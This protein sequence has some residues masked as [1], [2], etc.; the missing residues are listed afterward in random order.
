MTPPAV[1]R[2]PRAVVLAGGRGRRMGA[3][4]AMLD[5]GGEP[6]IRRLVAL[7]RETFHGVGV[8]VA[9]AAQGERIAAAVGEVDLYTDAS[10]GRGPL[11]GVRSA[12]AAIDDDRAF[13][14]A[15]DMPFFHAGLARV[16]WSA[17]LEG[18][19][20]GA[21][22]RWERGVEPACAVYSKGLLDEIAAAIERDD[23][24]LRQAATWP[25]VAEVDVEAATV[26]E[27]LGANF[28]P[29][30]VFFN[31]NTP[32]DLEAWKTRGRTE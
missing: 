6:L 24:A 18:G 13:F 17:S 7:L 30:N 4:K 2:L 12:L 19:G 5:A 3:D 25:G 10:P 21:V 8:S 20:R 27:T 28:R 11:E 9:D 15:V 31:L 23:I 1:D 29:R 16:L 22:P 14:L 26:R 32:E